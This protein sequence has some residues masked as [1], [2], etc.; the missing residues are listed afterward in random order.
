MNKFKLTVKN[1][2]L[3]IITLISISVILLSTFFYQQ[4][5]G[6]EEQLIIFSETT[7]PSVVLVKNIGN[8]ALTL[9]KDQFS[10]LP[11]V[12]HPK[13]QQWV[14][15]LDIIINDVD[16]ALAKYKQGLWDERDV[17]AY[18]DLEKSWLEYKSVSR[19]F[20]QLLSEEKITAANEYL[21]NSYSSFSKVS[22]SLS[23][24]EALNKNYM[25][26]DNVAAHQKVTDALTYG[27]GAI[28]VILIFMFSSS[29]ILIR[30]ISVPLNLVKEVAIKIAAGDLAYKLPREKIG[31]DELGEL[32]DACE[33]MQDK[34]L[35]LVGSLSNTALQV[36]TSIEEFSAIS[37]QT[38]HGMNEQQDQLNLIATAMNQMQSTVNDVATN[39][40]LASKSASDV[41]G[42]ASNGLDVVHLCIERT[43]KAQSVIEDT[44][45]M[46]TDV[47]Q[48]TN[49]I[50][51]VVDVIQDIAEQTNLLAL[52]AA[53]EAA[54][55][56]EQGRGFAVV[57]DEVRTLASRTQASTEEII[58]IIGKLQSRSKAAVEATHN[59]S[60]LID[61]CVKQAQA[62][63]ESIKEIEKGVDNIAEM[64]LQIASACSEQSSVTE[65]LNRNVVHINQSS[66]EVAQGA[67]ETTQ[68]CHDLTKLA[69]GLQ[70]IVTKFKIA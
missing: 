14:K 3:G 64:S 19:Q 6:I 44:G 41:K 2:I 62:A 52:N 12:N 9:R 56:G 60:E 53:I 63:G 28:S 69:T 24:L 36:S 57:A 18:N 11:N 5:K 38:S 49:N 50:S 43:H 54:R 40:E 25:D 58:E 29:A 47:A 46:V 7:V 32:A 68:A 59:S 42:E 37:A 30:Q 51:V 39:T 8:S 27:V 61:A 22:K 26:E 10:L 35:R 16:V 1:R 65:E 20:S 45:K 34:L 67:E 48:D 23:Q 21:L 13:I 4:I 15:D 17:T 31:N 70:D 66:S 55:A 33:N